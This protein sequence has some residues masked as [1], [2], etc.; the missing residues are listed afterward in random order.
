MQRSPWSKTHHGPDLLQCTQ[1]D[2]GDDVPDRRYWTAY[3]YFVAEREA[4][5]KRREYVYR[6]I[7]DAWRRMSDGLPRERRQA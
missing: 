3:D 7:V 5:G 4:R 2:T 1:H 6:L